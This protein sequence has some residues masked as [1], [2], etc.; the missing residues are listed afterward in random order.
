MKINLKGNTCSKQ[1]AYLILHKF[2]ADELA[3]ANREEVKKESFENPNWAYYQAY[4]A[5]TKKILMKLKEFI[6]DQEI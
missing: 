3:L 5:G 4:L 1:E 2:L 6:P